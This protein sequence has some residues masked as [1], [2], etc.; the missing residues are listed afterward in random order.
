MEKYIPQNLTRWTRPDCYI[1]PEYPACYYAPVRVNRDSDC[2]TRSNWRVVTE[3]LARTLAEDSPGIVRDSHW[4]C[5][6][7]EYFLIHESDA[8][9]LE[10]ADEWANALSDYPVASD[11]DFS[12]VESDEADETWRNCYD[13]PERLALIQHV[14]RN[15]HGFREPDSHGRY[16]G[17]SV[18][19]ARHDYAPWCE[20]GWITERLTGN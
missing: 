8:A 9:T 10:R 7:I 5:G 12:A 13:V 11:E 15:G 3:D 2:L 20:C 19:A 14:D 16:C 18:L 6:W 4:A 17:V 1:G